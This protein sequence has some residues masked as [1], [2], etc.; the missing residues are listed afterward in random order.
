MAGTDG[1]PVI[2]HE[3]GRLAKRRAGFRRTLNA[4]AEPGKGGLV[5]AGLKDDV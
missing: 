5:P 1:K 4:E 3:F 2:L